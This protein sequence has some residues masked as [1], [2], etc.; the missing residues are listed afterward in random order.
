MKTM[1]FSIV[2]NWPIGMEFFF[3]G[4]LLMSCTSAA[5][6]TKQKKGHKSNVHDVFHLIKTKSYVKITTF[7]LLHCFF[8][9]IFAGLLFNFSQR[10]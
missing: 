2:P 8:L 1:C 7:S 5:R 10:I 9:Y 3:P 6:V 4:S